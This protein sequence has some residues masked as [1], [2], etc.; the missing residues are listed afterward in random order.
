VEEEAMVGRDA[1]LI[2]VEPQ[3]DFTEGG[4]LPAPNA[5][6]A[7]KVINK[8]TPRFRYVI[9][10]KDWHPPDHCSFAKWPVHCVAG[11]IGA[12]FHFLLDQRNI[13]VIIH[14]GMERD[15]DAYSVFENTHLEAMLKADGIKRVYIT[16]F[17]LDVCVYETAVSAV[18]LGFDTY[19][20]LDAT[21]PAYPDQL[22]ETMAK[23]REAGV[24]VTNSADLS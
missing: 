5:S 13:R 4:A 21:K 6:E 18:A 17:A 24:K 9:A 19:I 22:K 14:T 10:S 3:N 16:G 1:A 7:I 8:V 20:V 15:D 23:I 12:K 2:V 11:T